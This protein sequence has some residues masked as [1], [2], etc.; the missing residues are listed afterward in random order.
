MARIDNA[1]I[2]VTK[3]ADPSVYAIGFD[4][5]DSTTIDVNEGWKVPWLHATFHSGIN[6]STNEFIAEAQEAMVRSRRSTSEIAFENYLRN[7]YGE[8]IIRI[9]P[10]PPESTSYQKIEI[11]TVS[12]DA[13]FYTMVAS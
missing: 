4:F 1:S 10:N 6:P 13:R 7:T 9:D 3:T 11:I 8:E 2:T 5:T 12:S